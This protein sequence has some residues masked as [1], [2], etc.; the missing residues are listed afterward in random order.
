MALRYQVVFGD[1]QNMSELP[2]ESVHLVVTSPPSP[3]SAS[4]PYKTG[5]GLGSQ[6]EH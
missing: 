1:A 2:D 6:T 3:S 5:K 4:K